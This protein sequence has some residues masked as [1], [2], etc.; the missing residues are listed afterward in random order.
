MRALSEIEHRIL[1]LVEPEAKAMGLDLVRVRLTGSRP[2]V[3]Q[4]MAEKPDGTMDVEDCARLSRR[5][6]PLLDAEDPIAGE[7]ALEVSSPGIDRPLTREGDFAKWAGHEVRVEIGTPVDGRK[8]FHGNIAGEE[9][10]AALLKLKDGGEAKIPLNEMV[11][12]HL[13]LTDAL[14]AAARGKGQAREIDDSGIEDGFD[15]VEVEDTEQDIGQDGD[16][17]VSASHKRK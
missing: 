10:G 3:L 5:L 16:E 1:D 11:K 9:D 8:R 6:S 14:I 4:I 15:D 7:Y 17:Q 13:V 2:P 12:A